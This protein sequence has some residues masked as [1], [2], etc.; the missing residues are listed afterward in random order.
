MCYTNHKVIYVVYIKLIY[1]HKCYFIYCICHILYTSGLNVE[2][3]LELPLFDFS[4]R[5]GQI[6]NDKLICIVN[7][8]AL[9][10]ILVSTINLYVPPLSRSHPK[11]RKVINIVFIK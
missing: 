3:F 7:C 4:E 9:E 2:K 10:I 11:N 5:L 1:V 8:G 6:E